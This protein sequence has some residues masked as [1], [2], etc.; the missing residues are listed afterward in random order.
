MEVNVDRERTMEEAPHSCEMAD[1]YVSTRFREDSDE[2]V[3][4][5]ISIGELV[6]RTGCQWIPEDLQADE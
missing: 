2:C 1:A 4:G 5:E 6:T 3:K